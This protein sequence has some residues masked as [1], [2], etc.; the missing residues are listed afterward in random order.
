MINTF[1]SLKQ[2]TISI[3]QGL[4]ITA[5]CLGVGYWSLHNGFND[6][7]ARTMVF[8]TLLFSNVFLTLVNR[9]FYHKIFT[10]IRYRNMLVPLIIG[11]TIIFIICILTIP[12][13][14]HLFGLQP[15][16]LNNIG[17]SIAVALV[18]TCWIEL[19]K[20]LGKR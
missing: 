20:P 1:L 7:A 8:V 19:F 3:I 15:L 13:L 11:I 16:M 17:I 4:F 18:S 2:L 12:F 10:T 9:S 5:G 14:R 6:E